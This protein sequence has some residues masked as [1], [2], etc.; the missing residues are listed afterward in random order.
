MN[1]EGAAGSTAMRFVVVL[2]FTLIEYALSVP[3]FMHGHLIFVS[4][5]RPYQCNR[6][7]KLF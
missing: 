4:C 1:V 3:L 5:L 6:V 7:L 2:W